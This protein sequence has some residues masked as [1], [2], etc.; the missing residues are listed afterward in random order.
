MGKFLGNGQNAKLAHAW[1]TPTEKWQG[2][3]AFVLVLSEKP[4]AESKQ[5]DFD[6]F[7]GKLGSALILKFTRSGDIFETEVYHQSLEKKPFSSVGTI[8]LGDYKRDDDLISGRLYTGGVDEF[9]GETW[10]VDLTFKTKLSK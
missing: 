4:A 2:K 5:P 7:F 9:F 1:A 10:E 6:A 8:K 3:G